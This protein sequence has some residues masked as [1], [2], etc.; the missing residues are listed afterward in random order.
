M[1]DVVKRKPVKKPFFFGPCIGWT[2]IS[3]VPR[4]SQAT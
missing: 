3:F 2:A 1:R 4:D